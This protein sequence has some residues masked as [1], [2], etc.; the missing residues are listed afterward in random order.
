VKEV[1]LVKPGASLA[2][3]AGRHIAIPFCLLINYRQQQ[4]AALF[5]AE[6]NSAGRF[7]STILRFFS[8]PS[9]D[10]APESAILSTGKTCV[11]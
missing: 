10:V 4:D 7:F 11:D 1:L 2:V 6:K 8:A 3:P 5:V 9:L